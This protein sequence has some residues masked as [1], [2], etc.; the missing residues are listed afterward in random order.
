MGSGD[1]YASGTGA[2]ANDADDGH[3]P[4]LE[5]LGGSSGGEYSKFDGVDRGVN[6]AR[7]HVDTQSNNDDDSPT[8]T[9]EE[10]LG[11]ISQ[12]EDAGYI[13]DGVDVSAGVGV[14]ARVG[15]GV[16]GLGVSL[17]VDIRVDLVVALPPSQFSRL[18]GSPSEIWEVL[19]LKIP[20]TLLMRF[21]LK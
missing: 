18:L 14:D 3:F 13:D 19:R 9:I 4:G 2:R 1:S 17:C 10:F 6:H 7:L 16:S 5:T 20:C 12:C 11:P 8:D 21:S 15:V